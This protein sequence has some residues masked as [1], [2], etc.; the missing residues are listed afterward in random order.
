MLDLQ[1]E[2]IDSKVKKYVK[3]IAEIYVGPFILYKHVW[4]VWKQ[5]KNSITDILC[6][7]LQYSWQFHQHIIVYSRGRNIR[8]TLL[9]HP[10]FSYD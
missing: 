7:I 8:H 5:I 4:S 3:D 6:S 2:W 10:V 1:W 9:D